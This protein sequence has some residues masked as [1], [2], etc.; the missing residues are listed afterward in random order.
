[1]KK[2]FLGIVLIFITTLIVLILNYKWVIKKSL[3][4]AGVRIERVEKISIGQW[5]LHNL[6]YQLDEKN[7]L[8]VNSVNISFLEIDVNAKKLDRYIQALNSK[9][10][11]KAVGIELQKFKLKSMSCFVH[12]KEGTTVEISQIHIPDFGSKN[13]GVL[14]LNL[15]TLKDIHLNYN[16]LDINHII[17]YFD[18]GLGLSGLID[19]EAKVNGD[20]TAKV[21]GKN[22]VLTG[23]RVDDVITNFLDTRSI[24]LID[25][26]AVVALGP[27]GLLYT[28][29]ASLGQTVGGFRGG[30]TN[31]KQ[32]NAAVT[33][34]GDLIVF[35][36]VAVATKEHLI[37]AQGGANIEKQTFKSFIVSVVDE[38]YCP[39][40]QQVIKGTFTKP[41]ISKTKAFL[42]TATAPVSSVK[43]STF[44]FVGVEKCKPIYKGVVKHPELD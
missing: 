11:V 38:K 8:K 27:I 12:K 10:K 42:D 21:S 25:A 43:S 13:R 40:L 32:I 4:M 9:I 37:I 23:F 24:G 19:L 3:A 35:D 16:N 31:L 17:K 14:T 39:E 2:I 20:I 6:K 7:E 44:Q 18:A 26:A 1:M 30:D 22:L 5:T 36:D 15:A 28:S 34:A 41:E 29:A 33:L